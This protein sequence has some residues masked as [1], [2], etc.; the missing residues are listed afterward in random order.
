MRIIK[1]KTLANYSLKF[2]NAASAITAW[3]YEIKYSNW[4]NAGEL[5]LK[6]ANASILTNKRVV[7]NIKGNHYRLIVDVEYKLKIMFIIWFGTHDEYDK[8]DAKNIRYED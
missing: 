4:N 5:K 7:F 2:P 8:L 1:E 6:Y 3:L